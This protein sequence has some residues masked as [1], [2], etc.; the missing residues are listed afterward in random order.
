L[1]SALKL[2]LPGLAL[3]L[4]SGSAYSDCSNANLA[5]PSYNPDTNAINLPLVKVLNDPTER[6]DFVEAKLQLVPGTGLFGFTLSGHTAV[7][8]DCVYVN[9]IATFDFS[10]DQLHLPILQVFAQTL[11]NTVFYYHAHLDR[12]TSQGVFR[13]NSLDAPKFA[14]IYGSGKHHFALATGS[15][16]ELGLLKVLAET[17]AEQENTTM[18]WRKAGS[19]ASLNLLKHQAVDMIMVHA[20]AAEKQA[21]ADGWASNRRLIGSNE[22]YIVGPTSDPAKIAE[23]SSAADAYARIANAQ[24]KFLSRG[25]NS[26]THK[27]ELFIWESATI[28]PEGDWYIITHDFMTATLKQANEELGYFMTDSSTW[29][30]ERQNLPNLTL[31]FRGDPVLVNVY[32]A[33]TAPDGATLGQAWALKFVEFVG[34]EQGQQIISD[35]GKPEYGESLYNDA[36][37]AKQYDH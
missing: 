31:L 26:G 37:Y 7:G 25:D 18:Y 11:G 19:G 6:L 33:L 10:N 17:F 24:A 29:V 16:G 36:V 5:N 22:F 4:G 28:S 23:A 1:K 30:A 13:L 3:S 32:H 34:S 27:K 9:P 14:G 8:E 15:P 21:V 35:Y 2:A 20:P 12:D